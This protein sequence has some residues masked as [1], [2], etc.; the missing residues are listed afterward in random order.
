[1]LA[2]SPVADVSASL[3]RRIDAV[4]SALAALDGEGTA[5]AESAARAVAMSLA[6]LSAAVALCEQAAWA[7]AGSGGERALLAAHRW[8]SERGPELPGAAP[9]AAPLARG[10]RRGGPG[11]GAGPSRRLAP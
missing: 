11:E 7:R 8:V 5:A 4:P 2:S 3:R 10:A 6:G 9:A 1:A